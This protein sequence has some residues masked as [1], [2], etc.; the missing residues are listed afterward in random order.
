M[1]RRDGI[2]VGFDASEASRAA[3]IWAAREARSRGCGLTIVHIADPACYDALVSTPL[4]RD[5]LRD[6]CRPVVEMARAIARQSEPD[7]RV[8]TIVR[9]GSAARLLV[10]LSG[11]AELVV[12]G[13]SGQ[14]ALSRL[15]LGS[16]SRRLMV[17]AH[18]P[19]VIV[20]QSPHGAGGRLNRVIAV[21]DAIAEQS[22]TLEFALDTAQRRWVPAHLLRVVSPWDSAPAELDEL[23]RA[24]A[25]WSRRYPA[26]DL[27]AEV[28][29]GSLRE[30]VANA[31]AS[32]DLVVLGDHRPHP[33]IRH[34]AGT[35]IRSVLDSAP[36]PVAVVHISRSIARAPAHPEQS[37]QLERSVT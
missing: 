11:R 33:L 20:G 13:R 32:G 31:C 5:E 10:A 17:D 16:V 14:G 34:N 18:C 19:T 27:H 24:L 6:R 21:V 37:R 36:C 26:V 2:L 25:T 29:A 8:H 30:G 1:Q 22:A 7:V 15:L 4:I 9:V 3:L 28:H 23:D 35:R 12:V